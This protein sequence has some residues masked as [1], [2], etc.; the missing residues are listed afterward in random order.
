MFHQVGSQ[1]LRGIFVNV[2]EPRVLDFR[3]VECLWYGFG[4]LTSL[5]GGDGTAEGGIDAES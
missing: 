2:E 3:L 5:V 4:G 1:L